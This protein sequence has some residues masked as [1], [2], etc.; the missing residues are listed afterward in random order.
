MAV[1]VAHH[2]IGIYPGDLLS[3]ET[4]LLRS[5][6]IDLRFVPER[7]RFER[8]ERFTGL[9]HRLDF[10]LVPGRGGLIAKLR[11]AHGVHRHK[12]VAAL[13]SQTDVADAGDAALA[14]NPDYVRADK[15]IALDRR[16]RTA[17]LRPNRRIEAAGGIEPERGIAHRRVAN[18]GV[19]VFERFIT[20][21][22]VLGRCIRRERKRAYSIVVEAAH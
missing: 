18:S 11:A 2:Q 17:G 7:D 21:G 12:Y 15:N 22:V 6:G 5:G 9:A 16:N 20:E 10:F 8:E 19:I 3:D 1:G 13:W 14:I 4:K